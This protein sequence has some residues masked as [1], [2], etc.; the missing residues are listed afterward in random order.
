MARLRQYFGNR[1]ASAEATN[2]EFENIVRYI[3]TAELGNLTIGELLAK[4]FD[5]SGELNLGLDFRFDPATGLE[6][7]LDPKLDEW[8]LV[9][10]S[11][12]LRGADGINVGSVESPLLS[13]RVDA[14]ATAGQTV[15]PY[16]MTSGAATL[17]VWVNG[18]L[19]NPA[20]YTHSTVSNTLTFGT[21]RGAGN[22]VTIASIRTS[23]STAYRRVD[24]TAAAGQVTF[25]FPHA[26]TEELIVFR[27][28][29]FQREGGGFDYV[30][31]P[32]T[33]TVTMTTS[34][35]AGTV[36]T[37]V[38]ITN[39]LI[40]DVAGLMLEDKYATN[41]MIR[42]DK[43]AIADGAIPMAKVAAL[44]STLST[45]ANITVSGS[46]PASAVNGDF[47]INTSA[48]VPALLFY[49]GVRWLSASP[50]G[51]VPLPQTANA[52]Q[53]LRLNSTA[54]ALE[55]APID[56]SALV[57]LNTVGLANGVAPL[58]SSGR[59]P[60]T[61]FPEFSLKAPIIG[62][63][64]GSIANS[65]IPV[66]LLSGSKHTFQGIAVRTTSGTCTVQLQVGGVN[67]GSTL[68]VTATATRLAISNIVSD[69]TATPRDVSLVVTAGATPV[70]LFYCIDNTITD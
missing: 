6:V 40:R 2:A 59:L 47:W 37:I 51:L 33:G 28:G 1:Y 14:V 39:S 69:A 48:A 35:V 10:S 17:M 23:P 46:Q 13:N 64:A 62:R 4:L 22:L 12:D 31:S 45:K 41:G 53:F 49:D 50:N 68:A 18:A 44:V 8:T 29:I 63:V 21:G 66:G 56:T 55:Y 70:D 60:T 30:K 11:S 54:T 34:Q 42:L 5:A 58:N 36:I 9:A 43:V 61:H 7:K 3:N 25:P 38:C 15:F 67:V 16:T 27:N 57:R 19:V 20:E 32:G 52:L 65:T 24:L 26:E